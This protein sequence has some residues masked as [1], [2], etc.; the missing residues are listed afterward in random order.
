MTIFNNTLIL[1]VATYNILNPYH[2]VKWQTI[3]GLTSDATL[4]PKEKL[5]SAAKSLEWMRYSNWEERKMHVSENLLLA[6]IVCLQEVATGTLSDLSELNSHYETAIHVNHQASTPF[7]KHGTAIIYDPMEVDLIEAHEIKYVSDKKRERF[8]ASATFNVAGKIIRVVSVH[9]KGYDSTEK[10]KTQREL[11]KNAGYKELLTYL[12]DAEKDTDGIDGI[13]IAGDFNE[14][15]SPEEK[16]SPLYRAG[17]LEKKGFFCDKNMTATEPA[18]GR[19][20]DWIYYKPLN[21]PKPFT[22]LTPM[23]LENKQ[24]VGSDHLMTGTAIEWKEN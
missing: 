2:A 16:S 12:A 13:I 20:I 4:L 19:R 23:D 7:S 8:A 10:D 3:E 6:S 22:L 24:K 14:D 18:T 1:S 11:S 15:P 17:L 5:N 9:L 21:T